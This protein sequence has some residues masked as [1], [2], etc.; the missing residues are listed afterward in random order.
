MSALMSA[1][2]SAMKRF[3]ARYKDFPP[4]SEVVSKVRVE[5][6]FHSE[7][8]IAGVHRWC[9]NVKLF[10]SK[11]SQYNTLRPTLAAGVTIKKKKK[12]SR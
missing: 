9:S 4:V 7:L 2:M 8:S 5:V 11:H 10:Y 12:K 1:L 6:K 3:T